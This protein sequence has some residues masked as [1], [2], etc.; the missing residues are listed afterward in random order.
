MNPSLRHYGVWDLP[1]GTVV[2]VSHG[3]YDHVALLG[4]R[5]VSGERGVVAF[6]ADAGGFVEQP[7]SALAGTRTVNVD[8]YLGKLPPAVVLQRARAMRG[9]SYSWA[10]FNCEHFVRQA[11]GLLVESPQLRRW[12]LLG[13]VVGLL[14]LGAAT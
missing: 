2:R 1:A 7:F 9:R 10:N 5:E 11:H 3:L 12:A 8:G 13:S 4:D 6:S 14:S